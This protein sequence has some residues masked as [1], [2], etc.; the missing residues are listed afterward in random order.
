MWVTPESSDP[1]YHFSPACYPPGQISGGQIGVGSPPIGIPGAEELA[2]R[3]A[4]S[5]KVARTN[6]MRFFITTPNGKWPQE[7]VDIH[8]NNFVHGRV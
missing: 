7:Y 8:I 6:N 4:E 2:N 1:L 3:V 5:S